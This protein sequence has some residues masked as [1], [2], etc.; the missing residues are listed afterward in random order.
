MP[1]IVYD[2]PDPVNRK[3]NGADIYKYFTDNN[4]KRRKLILGFEKITADYTSVCSLIS[5]RINNSCVDGLS[6][7]TKSNTHSVV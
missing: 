5:K 6:F 7:D 4:K 1:I 2:L 3:Y